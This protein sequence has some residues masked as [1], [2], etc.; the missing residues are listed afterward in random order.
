MSMPSATPID[1]TTYAAVNAVLYRLASRFPVHEAILFGSRAQGSARPENDADLAVVLRGA[2][3]PF[4]QTKLSIADIAFDAMLE[5]GTMVQPL[6]LWDA[7][8]RKPDQW[9]NPE[10]LRNIERTGIRVWQASSP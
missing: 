5:T 10:L 2:R 6:P 3:G 9:L 7:D 4:M 1:A 8:L